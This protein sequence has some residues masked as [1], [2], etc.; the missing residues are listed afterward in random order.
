MAYW[1]LFSYMKAPYFSLSLLGALLCHSIP[2][3]LGQIHHCQLPN[4][5]Q[6][7]ARN[8]PGKSCG[9][10]ESVVSDLEA[11]KSLFPPQQSSPSYVLA[12]I[13]YSLISLQL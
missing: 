4:T 5:G 12:V 6:E 13:S 9:Y 11:S 2:S 8:T 10:S 1:Q 7:T 3:T